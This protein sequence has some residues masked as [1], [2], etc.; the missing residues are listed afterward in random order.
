M[1]T[2]SDSNKSMI[3]DTNIGKPR[4]SEL[5]NKGKVFSSLKVFSDQA[6]QFS[7]FLP[8]LDVSFSSQLASDLSSSVLITHCHQRLKEERHKEVA[9]SRRLHQKNLGL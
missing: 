3:L 1:R 5:I 7:V 2:H 4:H 9:T 8:T 6:T